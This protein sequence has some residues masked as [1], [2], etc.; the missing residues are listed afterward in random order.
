MQILPPPPSSSERVFA[1]FRTD[2][3]EG[4]EKRV[5]KEEEACEGSIKNRSQEGKIQAN[6]EEQQ[7]EAASRTR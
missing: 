7:S 3:N 4:R 2:A 1:V 5:E 6:L